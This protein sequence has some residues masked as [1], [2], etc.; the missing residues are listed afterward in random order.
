MRAKKVNENVNFERGGDP[1]RSMGIGLSKIIFDKWTEFQLQPG[2]GSINIE[3][4]FNRNWH[5]TLHVSLFPGSPSKANKLAKEYF[6]DYL[7]DGYNFKGG[8][9]KIII[10]PEYVNDFIKAY[11]MRYPDWP[12][13]VNESV[14]F[15]RG[16]DPKKSMGIGLHWDNLKKGS[17]LEVTK[18]MGVTSSGIVTSGAPYDNI[19]PGNIIVLSEPIT[20]FL[21][22]WI[23]RG[24]HW[25]NLESYLNGEK[26]YGWDEFRAK[27]GTLK[28]R[29]KIISLESLHESLDF[30]REGTPYEKLGIGE[31]V[32]K[33]KIIQEFPHLRNAIIK[34]IVP[35][36]KYKIILLDDYIYRGSPTDYRYV[37]VVD[38][39][40][41]YT[42]TPFYT[43]LNRAL[44][45]IKKVIGKKAYL[46]QRA[47]EIDWDWSP[48]LPH[49]EVLDIIEYKGFHIKISK[50]IQP[51]GNISYFGD[52]DTGEPY[53]M[54]P[55]FHED[56]EQALFQVQHFL[57]EFSEQ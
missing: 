38:L 22:E 18:R 48:H 1:K 33:E 6:G 4:S 42:V 49:E 13:G 26:G 8:E 9:I 15:E 30:E 14:N 44:H 3:E 11:N 34:K 2:I 20:D 56:P 27:L 45:R 32:L 41:D 36:K 31:K 23:V 52:S 53:L 10:K 40:G 16:G 28:N 7:N 35:Y 47:K 54:Q 21:D 29:M 57:D 51:G 25:G 24:N 17:V 55:D 37:A 5:L 50:I 12:I 19:S 43:T 39:D 46:E